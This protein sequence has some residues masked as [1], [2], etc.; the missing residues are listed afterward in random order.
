MRKWIRR[1]HI[2]GQANRQAHADLPE[3][4]VERELGKEASSARLRTCCIRGHRPA[5]RNGK[6]RCARARS[7]A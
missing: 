5:G 4:T 2:E 7:I 3:G 6:A 1:P